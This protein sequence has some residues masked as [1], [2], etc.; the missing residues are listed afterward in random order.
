MNKE[1]QAIRL[2]IS[3]E[4]LDLMYVVCAY[5]WLCVNVQKRN[6]NSY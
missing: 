6:Q 5:N 2:F 4:Q 1:D 3:P